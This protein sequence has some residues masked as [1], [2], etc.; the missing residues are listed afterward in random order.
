[1]SLQ[2]VLSI[3]GK[4]S[5]GSSVRT[6]NVIA[7]NSV[8]NI[9]KSSLGPVGLDKMI[10]DDVGD[11]TVTNDGATILKLLEVEHP[12]AR[13]LVELAQLQDDEVGDGTTS[14][15]IIAAELLKAADE[16]VKQKIH[17][18]SIIA[19]YKLACK[20]ACRYIQNN[21]TISTDELGKDCVV[22]AARTTMSSKVVS[23]DSEFFGQMVVDAATAVRVSDGKGGSKYPIKAVNILKA[24]GRSA[25]ESVLVDGYA[26]NCTIASHAMTKKIIGAKIACLDFNLQKEKMKLGVH[27]LLSDPDK[28]DAIRQREA[29]ITKER[30][31]KILKAGA[32][33]VLTTQGIDDLCLKY[34]VEAGAMAVRRVKKVD[35]KRIAKATGATLLTTLCNLE[36]EETFETSYLGEA[37]EVAQERICDDELILIKGPSARSAASIILRGPNDFY[38]DEMERS[39][40]DALCVVR[41]VLESSSVVCGGG[42]VEAALSVYLENF[43]T[44]L[45]SREQLAIAAF[46]QSLLVIP[47]TLTVNA[48]RDATELVPKLRAFH[49][50]SQV[51]A[52]HK[53]LKYFGLDL[54]EG[55]VRDNREAGVFEPGMS[56]IK[57]L[58]FATEAAIT[59]L[60]IDDMIRLEPEQK[61]ESH[62]QNARRQGML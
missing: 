49:H 55:T 33:V 19:G 36:G 39:I 41:R 52:E 17:P 54:M 24:H 38:C 47:N 13:V 11:V 1:M 29:D 8:A 12:A 37:A 40:H 23:V 22:A 7:A 15:V 26:L 53:K 34:F 25:R 35:M 14:V 43:A 10:V 16:L 60:R 18:T 27:V 59:I 57:Q 21:L 62:Y 48:A 44:T 58:K 4:R 31:S 50:S 2:S 46:A 32:N 3:P 51:K 20:E 30:I 61:E 45:S 42:S 56:K 6:E 9:L 28:L 5:T